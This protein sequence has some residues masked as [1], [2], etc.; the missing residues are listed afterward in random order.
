MQTPSEDG[1][2]MGIR[3]LK[4]A[5]GRSVS[6]SPAVE[7]VR[8]HEPLRRS[9]GFGDAEPVR[10]L[11]GDGAGGRDPDDEPLSRIVAAL[12]ERFGLGLTD[13]DG[14]HLLS[15][16]RDLIADPA[17]QVQAAANSPEG[18]RGILDGGLDQALVR[19]NEDNTALT[20]RIFDDPSLRRDLIDRLLPLIHGGARVAYQEHCPIGE[21]LA[22]REDAHL[23]RKS[24]PPMGH[25]EGR[26]LEGDRDRRPEDDRGVP[27]RPRRR[28]AADRS[29]RR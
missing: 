14:L 1:T 8:L 28:D 6:G 15:V 4:L 18:F 3:S 12:D 20:Y 16:A 21:L 24:T 26:A 2:Q 7:A 22:R 13:A 19:R 9:V 29:P 11:A 27:E 5:Y 17:L 23:E 10:S 25:R